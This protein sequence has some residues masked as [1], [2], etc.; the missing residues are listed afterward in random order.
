ML[1]LRKF[2]F[3]FFL[4][5]AFTVHAQKDFTISSPDGSLQLRVDAAA[6][7]QWSLNHQSQAIIAPSSMSLTLQSGEVL[8]ANPKVRTPLSVGAKFEKIND[9]IT[10]L[11]Y[12]KQVVEDR[13][14]E[15]TLNCKGDY[16]V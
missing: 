6:K 13:Y 1:R 5:A 8:G 2:C 4:P 11:N 10:A 15:L 14:N 9:K 7:F 16:G 3:L 12:K